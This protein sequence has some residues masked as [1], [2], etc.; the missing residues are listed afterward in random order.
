ML[1]FNSM[2]CP[3]CKKKFIPAFEHIYKIKIKSENKFKKVCSY[4]CQNLYEKA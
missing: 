4:K 3:V 1:E 2:I